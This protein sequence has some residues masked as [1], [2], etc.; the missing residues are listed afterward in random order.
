[1]W[2]LGHIQQHVYLYIFI[3]ATLEGP[4]T[5]FLSA[6]FSAQGF[7]RIDYV[8]VL[9][10]FGDVIF[11]IFL[12][13][14]GRWSH[15]LQFLT[16]FKYFSQQKDKLKKQIHKNLFL[17]LLLVKTTPYLA[18]PW[19]MF[20]WRQKVPIKQFLTQSIVITLFVK[21]LYLLIWYFGFVWLQQ[22]NHILQWR[23]QIAMYLISG[24]VLFVVSRKIYIFLWKKIKKTLY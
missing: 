16:R 11:D 18:S 5:T 4:I 7:L 13:F 12:Y 23:K 21:S 20:A 15:K 2:L 24:I 14:I 8:I 19:L 17:Y 6:G 22:F 10:V 1:M 3:L 9:V